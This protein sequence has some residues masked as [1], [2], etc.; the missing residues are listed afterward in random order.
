MAVNATANLLFWSCT[1]KRHSH[2][3]ASQKQVKLKKKRAHF[4]LFLKKIMHKVVR[5]L[6]E[7]KE[8]NGLI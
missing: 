2:Q 1:K 8:T 5:M 3:P 7:V 6:F 4:W